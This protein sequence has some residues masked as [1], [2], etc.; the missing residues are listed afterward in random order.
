MNTLAVQLEQILRSAEMR[1]ERIANSFRASFYL[2]SALMLV[3]NLGIN[4]PEANAGFAVQVAAMLT[5]SALV[6][7]WFRLRPHAY[8][9][10]LK[11]VTITLDLVALHAGAWIMQQNHHGVLEYFQAF[12]PLVLVLFN[13]VSVLRY[14]VAA[15]LYSGA[16]SLGLSTLVLV[17][18]SQSGQ[19]ALSPVSVWGQQAINLGDEGARVVFIALPAFAAAYFAHLSRGLILR[20]EAESLHRARL[21]KQKEQLSKYLSK[22]L[23]AAVLDNPEL[24]EL[25]GS[26]RY[27]TILFSDIR[28][29]TPLAEGAEPERVVALLNEYFTAM[30]RIVFRYGGTLDK[31]MGD[32]LMA[33]F[34]APFDLKDQELRATL[35]AVEM[36]QAV[37]LFNERHQLEARG[38][39]RLTIGVGI[40]SGPVV[41]G[42]IG[43]PERMEYTSIGDTVNFA[44][45][46]E[47]LN[48]SLGTHVLLSEA[49]FAALD[50]R[51]PTLPMPPIQIKGKSGTPPVYALDTD[52]VDPERFARLQDEALRPAP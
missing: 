40:A 23:T 10:W 30:V 15:C 46:L 38:L 51:L 35:V 24:F 1:G 39:P 52:R 36:V 34:G 42:N 47:S 32:G 21:E 27:A 50:G 31:F 8:A 25:G 22:D 3:A 11:Y 5:V 45:R 12:V 41:A 43:S 7:L 19:V 29:F 17:W 20:A 37:R 6:W 49:T 2:L 44:A 26:R 9:P 48:K 14:S 28:N 13:V 4:K 33:V 18:A 16:L